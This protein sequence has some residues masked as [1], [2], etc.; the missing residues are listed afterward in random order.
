MEMAAGSTPLGISSSSKMTLWGKAWLFLN[1][2]ASPA[3]TLNSPGTKASDP[4]L[5]PSSTSMASALPVASSVLAAAATAA[6]FTSLREALADTPATFARGAATA[7]MA[8]DLAAVALRPV[9]EGMATAVVVMLAIAHAV[10]VFLN[11]LKLQWK[12]TYI[13]RERKRK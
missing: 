10:T 12:A 2:I 1:T 8:P 13:Y 4:S 7:T 5:P 6:T 9:K 3:A 11:Q